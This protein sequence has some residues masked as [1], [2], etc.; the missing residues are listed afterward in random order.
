VPISTRRKRR[1]MNRVRVQHAQTERGDGPTSRIDRVKQLRRCLIE[2]RQGYYSSD[3]YVDNGVKLLRITD[4][5]D[6]GGVEFSDCPHVELGPELVPFYLATD[7]FVFA[8][9]G[10]AGRFGL[11]SALTVPAVYAAYLIRFRFSKLMHPRY[12]R[13]YFMT[14]EFQAQLQSRIHGGVNQN[15]HAEDIKEQYVPVPDLNDQIAIAEFLERETARFERLGSQT[16]AAIALLQE[17]RSTLISAAV[18]GKIDVRGLAP[19]QAEAA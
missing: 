13:F 14:A 9:T 15:L 18:T 1:P 2:H 10:G 19:S 16:E 12:L 8:R 7:D 6:D 11:I 5:L 4:L 17:R 3:E